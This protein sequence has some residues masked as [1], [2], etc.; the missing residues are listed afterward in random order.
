VEVMLAR[1]SCVWVPLFHIPIPKRHNPIIFF[2]TTY[3]IHTSAEMTESASEIT[4]SGSVDPRLVEGKIWEF[5]K[6][7]SSELGMEFFLKLR[8]RASENSL[9]EYTYVHATN[10]ILELLG[11]K[12]D[13]D[14][15]EAA[16]R[17]D[18][19]IGLPHSVL[20]MRLADLVGKPYIWR[21]GE[22]YVEL[23]KALIAEITG[24]SEVEL[25]PLDNPPF[26]DHLTHLVG[27]VIINI[28]SNLR[29]AGELRGLLRLYNALW[30]ALYGV[31]PPQKEG[32]VIIF[33]DLDKA[34][35]AEVIIK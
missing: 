10:T 9:R 18:S 15:I 11:G 16:W 4:V 30:Y 7:L 8:V 32:L 22:E 17:I 33:P 28:F 27:S 21:L 6:S 14:V 29:E 2:P 5:I 12:L 34:F 26:A 31:A 25:H 35:S 3:E 1:S 24:V 23:D 20:G 19:K 13:R